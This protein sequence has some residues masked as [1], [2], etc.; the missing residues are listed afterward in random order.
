MSR[1]LEIYIAIEP[2]LGPKAAKALIVYI[3]QRIYRGVEVSMMETLEL[4][5]L[6][7]PIF[8]EKA[9]S[10]I[11]YIDQKAKDNQVIPDPISFEAKEKA[12]LFWSKLFK[13]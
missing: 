8:G 11:A 7:K 1:F 12:N 3:E 6:L 9:Q 4:Y 10:L 13:T 5:D 2:T